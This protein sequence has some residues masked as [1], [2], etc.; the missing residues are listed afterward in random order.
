M[1]LTEFEAKRKWCPYANEKSRKAIGVS[2]SEGCIAAEC[3]MWKRHRIDC[4]N[5]EQCLKEYITG[6]CGLAFK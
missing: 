3:M 4:D 1:I 5:P 2:L 6:Y